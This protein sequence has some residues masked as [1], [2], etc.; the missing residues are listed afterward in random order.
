MKAPAL[1]LASFL[2][3][4]VPFGL[5]L[6]RLLGVDVRRHG[7]G[8]IGATN[9]GRAAGRAAGIVTLLLD[10]AKGAMGSGLAMAAGLGPAWAAACGGAAVAGHCWTPWLAGK[11]GKGVATLIG[12]FA[13]LDTPAAALGG[14]AFG[15][16]LGWTRV[17]AIASLALSLGLL[18]AVGARH[19]LGDPRA[20]LAC[21][22]VALVAFRHQANWRRLRRGEEPRVLVRRARG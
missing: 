5:I 20:L 1:L 18:L 4:S 14:V 21:G 16:A 6:G 15:V 17:E 12:A 3:G 13:V 11:G 19:G 10:G 22:G 9:V 7:S 8:N 2:I